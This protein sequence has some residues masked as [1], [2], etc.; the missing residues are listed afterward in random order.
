M[1]F[2]K[3]SEWIK[4]QRSKMSK[5]DKSLSQKPVH[6]TQQMQNMNIFRNGVLR[7]GFILIPSIE[8]FVISHQLPF[9]SK[10]YF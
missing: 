9:L 1:S 8:V 4:R 5:I 10:I 3:L 7:L 2:E 6:V